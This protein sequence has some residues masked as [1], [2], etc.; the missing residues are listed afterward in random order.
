[1][2]P[3]ESVETAAR[4]EVWEE[5]RLQLETTQFLPK[6]VIS[7]G[8]INQ[9]HHVFSVHLEEVP[10]VIAVAPEAL[11]VRWFSEVECIAARAGFWDP[12]ANVNYERL[13]RTLRERRAEVYQWN[14]DYQRIIG[15]DGR[16]EYVWRRSD[17]SGR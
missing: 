9:V 14:D 7:V 15:S 17:A 8:H 11:E 3:G 10:P 12:A 16:I 13:F 5:T 4:R 2:E 6:G 1:M